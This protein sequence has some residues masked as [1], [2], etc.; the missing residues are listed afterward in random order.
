MS[1]KIGIILI[2]YHDY[3]RRF[4]EACR[5]SLRLQN[6]PADKVIVYIVD[7]ASSAGTREF[8]TQ[9][10]P[11]AKILFR[12]DGNYS[13]ANNLGF[14]QAVADG[15]DYLVTVNMDTEM[16]PDWLSE[17]VQALE[18]DPSVGV[19]QSKVLLFPQN[20]EEKNSPRL[21]TL[22]NHC[23]F[24]GFGTTSA[25]GEKDREISGYPEIRGYASGCC[26]IVKRELFEQIGGWNEEYYMYHDDIEFSFKAR[27]AGYKIVLAPKSRIF[28]KYEF[29]RSVRMLYYM[30]RNRYLL[31][32][33][34][35][36]RR[37]LLFLA[38]AFIIMDLGL[39]IFSLSKGWA[40][41]WLKVRFYFLKPGTWWRI[42]KER[43]H[44]QNIAKKDFSALAED[45]KGKLEFTE[46]DNPLLQYI[47]NPL[48]NFYWAAV[49]RLAIKRT[50][51]NF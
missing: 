20:E 8:L 39:L 12:S 30:E 41:T 42:R 10:Y 19:S 50:D 15:C 24:L 35:Y 48:L 6:Y 18:S 3:A 16:A 14:R 13:A 32:F 49:K 27:L 37:L 33:S 44:F 29:S 22:G 26:F 51:K 46:I 9:I 31:A 21:N 1:K 23:H 4:L 5:D 34:F 17:L 43:R 40:R 45:F 38:P 2:N 7:N 11:E 36:P 47:G 25:Y 28:H